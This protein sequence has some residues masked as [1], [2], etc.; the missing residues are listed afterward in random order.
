MFTDFLPQEGGG[1]SY[2]WLLPSPKIFLP[3]KTFHKDGINIYS[4][5]M[6]CYIYNT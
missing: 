1:A 4:M 3:F 6:L 2:K 5:A